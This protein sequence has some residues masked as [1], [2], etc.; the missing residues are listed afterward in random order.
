MS[1]GS[2]LFVGNFL[3]DAGSNRT[4]CEELSDRMETLGWQV[5]RTSSRRS[6]LLR[7]VDM[8]AATWKHRTAYGVAHVDVFSGAAFLWA[9]AVCLELKRLRKPYVLTLRGGSLPV[10][11]QRNRLRVRRLLKSAAIVTSPSRYLADAL[12]DSATDIRVIP[13]AIESASYEY[14]RRTPATPRLVWIRAFHR[15]YNPAMAIDALS[16]C[17]HSDATLTMIGVDKR[18]G[19]LDEVRQ[20]IRDLQLEQRVRLITGVPKAEVP[21]YLRDADIFLNTTN[22][23]NSPISVLEAM[24]AGLCVVST[25]VGGIRYVL[26]DQVDAWLVGPGDSVAMS[27]AIDTIVGDAVLAGQLSQ[28]AHDHASARDWQY[29]LREWETIFHSVASNA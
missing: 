9:E 27:N 29:V 28:T 5:V 11:A 24:A 19:S 7:L 13:N 8:L 23:D 15:V 3:S 6:R 20:R 4:Y 21:R 2:L 14:R 17:R 16:A 26:R 18:D 25:N 1:A 12:S 22:V 10:F